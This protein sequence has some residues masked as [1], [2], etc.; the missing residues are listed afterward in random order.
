MQSFRGFLSSP[1]LFYPASGP[2]TPPPPPPS[3]HPPTLSTR[4]VSK[5]APSESSKGDRGGNESSHF[6]YRVPL[7]CSGTAA[8]GHAWETGS[9]V[10][11]FHGSLGIQNDHWRALSLKTGCHCLSSGKPVLS[12]TGGPA[13]SALFK[14]LNMQ[15]MRDDCTWRSWGR[16]I[17]D[18]HGEKCGAV[19]FWILSLTVH[20]GC[21]LWVFKADS[22]ILAW[23]IDLKK[24]WWENVLVNWTTN[25]VLWQ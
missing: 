3:T 7:L 10:L 21:D 19:F 17:S 6:K 2:L 24:N 11:G 4:R 22:S 18:S 13:A 1:L 9:Q 25:Q 12:E 8:V 23:N 20:W 14:S 16:F 15:G 5:S